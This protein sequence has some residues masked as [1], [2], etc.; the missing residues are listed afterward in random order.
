MRETS[1]HAVIEL[2]VLTHRRSQ[3]MRWPHAPWIAFLLGT[4]VVVLG[5][6]SLVGHIVNG[7]PSWFDVVIGIYLICGGAGVL[8]LG[9]QARTRIDRP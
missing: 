9:V 4:I 1:V 6:V 3:I 5:T 7:S 2:A 8:V